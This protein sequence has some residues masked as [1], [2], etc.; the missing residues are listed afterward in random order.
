MLR[1]V[2]LHYIYTHTYTFA[3]PCAAVFMLRS[4]GPG[5]CVASEM[6]DDDAPKDD[7]YGPYGGICAASCRATRIILC[8]NFPNRPPAVADPGFAMVN[9]LHALEKR[10][11][12]EPF[13]SVRKWGY[14]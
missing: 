13:G 7:P 9:I 4:Q 10:K 11:V 2:T 3:Y 1:Y 12:F 6:Y 5:S 14:P 8:R